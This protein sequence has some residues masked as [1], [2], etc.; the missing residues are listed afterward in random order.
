MIRKIKLS[1]KDDEDKAIKHRL[2]MRERGEKLG[3][4][5]NTLKF[6]DC[7]RMIKSKVTNYGHLFV[8]YIH[9]KI[10]RQLFYLKFLSKPD[11]LGKRNSICVGKIR[12]KITN[13]RATHSITVSE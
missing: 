13:H 7:I 9:K 11:F 12:R 5:E 1:D 3:V 6:T 10:G 4:L 2:R 8:A